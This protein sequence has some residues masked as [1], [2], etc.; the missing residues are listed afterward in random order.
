M[1]VNI[2]MI[3]CNIILTAYNMILILIHSS[4]LSQQ[5]NLYQNF[6]GFE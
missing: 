6:A 3:T 2:W 4:K 5:V 1:T